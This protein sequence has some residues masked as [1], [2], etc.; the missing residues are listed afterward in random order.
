M[1]HLFD[2]GYNVKYNRS[3][4][5]W[6]TPTKA[7]TLPVPIVGYT[8]CVPCMSGSAHLCKLLEKIQKYKFIFENQ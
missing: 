4:H 5:T 2:N 8:L 7:Q 6:Q 3:R 1:K